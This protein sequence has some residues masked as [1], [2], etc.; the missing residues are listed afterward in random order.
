SDLVVSASE[1]LREWSAKM[2]PV[3]MAPDEEARCTIINGLLREG[4]SRVYLT[5]HDQLSPHLHFTSDNDDGVSRVKTATAGGLAIFT[6]ESQGARLGACQIKDCP[7]V[8]V[9]TSRNGR[10]RYCMAKCGNRSGVQRHRSM[11]RSAFGS[12]FGSGS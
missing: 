2:R 12:E 11:P 6:V 9:D 7:E 8:F 10:R 1:N 5:I 3:F 4:T